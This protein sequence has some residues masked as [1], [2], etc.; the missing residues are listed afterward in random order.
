MNFS[1]AD[2]VVS[3]VLVVAMCVVLWL[4]SFWV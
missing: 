3:L 2:M 4:W 1:E